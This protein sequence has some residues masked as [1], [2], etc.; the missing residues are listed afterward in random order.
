MLAAMT[1]IAVLLPLLLAAAPDEPAAPPA[2][3]ATGPYECWAFKAPRLTLNFT[4]TGP[5]KYR[6]ADGGDGTYR[7]DPATGAIE[8][9]GYLGDALPEKFTSKYHEPKGRPTVS[10]RG[11]GGSEAS[12]CEKTR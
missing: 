11:P 3:V 10:F 7:Y 4:V 6:D 9:T 12:Y 1:P 2:A 8:F 5:G